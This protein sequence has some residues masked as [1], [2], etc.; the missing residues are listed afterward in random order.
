MSSQ[1]SS[2]RARGLLVL[3]V[4]GVSSA[5]VITSWLL[6]ADPDPRRTISLALWRCGGAAAV[7]A[8]VSLRTRR[9]RLGPRQVR[10]LALSGM[11]LGVHFA[12]FLGSLA[13]TSVASS[14]TLATMAPIVVAVGSVVWLREPP[15]RRTMVGMGITLVAAVALGA[16][17][18]LAVTG[19]RA[20]VGDLMA[21]A[22]AVVISGSLVIGRAERAAIPAVQYSTIVFGVASATLVVVVAVTGSPWMPWQGTEWLAVAGMVI[23]PQLVGHFLIQTLL[24]DIPPVVVSTAV[25]AEPIFASALA[26]VFLGQLPPVGLYVTAPLV[27]L[28]VAIAITGRRVGRAPTEQVPVE[29]I[30]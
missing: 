3:A 2:R 10:R 13:F 24:S 6:V 4:L 29:P 17:D 16:T 11:L 20:I 8:V 9:V 1:V 5:A 7:L 25:L 28:G 30:G 27:L 23:G 18:L 15:T 12:L 14:T 19:T 22:S 26:F 21:F